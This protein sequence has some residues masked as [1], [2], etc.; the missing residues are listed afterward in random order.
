MARY[1]YDGLTRYLQVR[2][3][4]EMG[5]DCMGRLYM[6]GNNRAMDLFLL[7][8]FS[9]KMTLNLSARNRHSQLYILTCIQRRLTA[10]SD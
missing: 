9:N 6:S 10:R 3:K 8:D 1:Q 5:L 7:Q 2:A 4:C